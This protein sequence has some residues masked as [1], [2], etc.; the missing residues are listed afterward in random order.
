MGKFRICI[1]GREKTMGWWGKLVGGTVGFMLGGPLGA[2]LG[3]AL[4][5][6]LDSANAQ[7]HLGGSSKERTQSA[8]AREGSG[9]FAPTRSCWSRHHLKP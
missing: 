1:Q 8:G 7:Q 9:H 4:G 6:Q 2:M 5:H 3:T